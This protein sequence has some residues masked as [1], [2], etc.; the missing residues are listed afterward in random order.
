M[1]EQVC[2]DQ[3]VH[4]EGDEKKERQARDTSFKDCVVRVE[5]ISGGYIMDV[6]G[7][8]YGPNGLSLEV[9]VSKG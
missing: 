9:K 6:V 8:Q 4:K 7:K 1:M 3:R 5:E 2:K